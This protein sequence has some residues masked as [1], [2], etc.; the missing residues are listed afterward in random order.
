M[1]TNHKPLDSELPSAAQLMKS[2]IIAVVIAAV[3][4]IIAV[5]PAEYGIDPTGVGKL[6][7]LSKM[8][9]IKT[10]LA[11][12]A[13]LSTPTPIPAPLKKT[14]GTPLEPKNA[15]TETTTQTI[16]PT[17]SD[18]ISFTLRP[19]E[20]R[21]LKLVMQKGAQVTFIWQTDGSK[22]NFDTHADSRKLEINYH[23]YA[24]GST[25]YSEGL[26]EAAFDGNHGWFWRNRS[27]KTMII[28]LEV[29]GDYSE[30]IR[31]A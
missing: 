27:G 13:A 20:A 19:D 9:E 15:I 31:V 21:E 3:I 14:T 17:K 23:N 1:N 8:G 7:G 4:L 25:N 22:A 2:T 30:I 6:L 24:K 11:K 18:T 26:M 10:S 16:A 5:L 12:E 28:T 29:H